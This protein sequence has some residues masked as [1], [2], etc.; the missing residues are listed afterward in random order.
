MD[1]VARPPGAALPRTVIALGAVSLL[2]DVSSEML[3]PVLPLFLTGVL[4]A[5]MVSLGLIEGIAE[6]TASVLR[7]GSGWLSDHVGRRKPFLVAGYG[8][9]TLAKGAMAFAQG[10]PALLGLRFADR[11][12]KG[13]RNPPRD[14]LIA[15]TTPPQL[16]GRAFGLHRA[17]DTLGAAVGPLL[18]AV[19]LASW[20]A[21]GD[22]ALRRVFL[23]SAV[24][25]ALAVL[26][27]VLAVRA[28]PP[29]PAPSRPLAAQARALG[30]PFVRFL[31]ADGVFQLG[32]SSMA[33]VLLRL[34][35]AG[36]SPG[37][38]AL[39]YAGYN[40]LYAALSLPLGAFSDRVGRRPLLLAGY[41]VYALAYAVLAWAATRAGVLVALALLAAFSALIEGQARSL[42]ADLV[43]PEVRATAFG[44][45]HGVVGMALLPASLAAGLL[46]ERVGAGAAFALGAGLALLAGVLFALLLPPRRE[47]AE[48]FA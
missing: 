9:S 41:A 6:C 26:V 33:F 42:V 27:L 46:W 29:R 45:Y 16:R 34:Q 14:A 12:G 43:A 5:S 13:M 15:D 17:M 11:V 39:A 8:L 24:P 47:Q 44:V 4:G 28:G 31:L 40:L 3:V 22:E 19:L 32:N 20:A 2:T 36:W 48:R 7:I 25:G 10:W 38:V 30:A 35:A 37:Q 21:A 23:V 18:A 1:P